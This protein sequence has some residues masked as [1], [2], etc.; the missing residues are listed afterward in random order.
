MS[1]PSVFVMLACRPSVRRY[2]TS[3]VVVVLPFTP[4]TATIGMRPVRLSPNI[5]DDRL[6][7]AAGSRRSEVHPQP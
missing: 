6:A 7:P 2:M 3:R 4:V 1:V 5:I